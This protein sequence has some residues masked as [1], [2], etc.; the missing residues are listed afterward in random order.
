MFNDL[1]EDKYLKLHKEWIFKGKKYTETDLGN[2]TKLK[3]HF[4]NITIEITG[5]YE[6]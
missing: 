3:S 2:F 5:F 6:K 4:Q 1:C